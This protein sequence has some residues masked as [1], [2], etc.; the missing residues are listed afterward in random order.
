[1]VGKI[2]KSI[3]GD[4]YVQIVDERNGYYFFQKLKKNG[5]LYPKRRYDS[6]SNFISEYAQ[7]KLVGDMQDYLREMKQKSVVISNESTIGKVFYMTWGYGMSLVEFVRVVDETPKTVTVVKL[8]TNVIGDT[9][10]S[11]GKIMPINKFDG[12]P[13]KLSKSLNNRGEIELRG[14][15]K[16]D[17]YNDRESRTWYLWD[18]QP[19]YYNTWD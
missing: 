14:S 16:S 3:Y 19:K 2:Y 1:M 17:G 7:W 11:G 15:D 8:K 4:N 12:Q 6:I 9:D 10:P 13:F 5:E 18:G